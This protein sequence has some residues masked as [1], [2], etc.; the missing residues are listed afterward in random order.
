MLHSHKSLT[1]LIRYFKNKHLGK[2]CFIIGNGPSINLMDLDCLKN[3][4]TIGTNYTFLK[5]EIK[6]PYICI[7]DT[8]RMQ[9]LALY[10][11]NIFS[12]KIIFYASHTGPTWDSIVPS[13]LNRTVVL[14]FLENEINFSEDIKKGIYCNKKM[15]SVVF[16]AIQIAV[17]MGASEIYLI[18]VDQD[19]KKDQLWFHGKQGKPHKEMQCNG[20]RNVIGHNFNYSYETQFKPAIEFYHEK[21]KEKNIKLINAGVGGKLDAIPRIKFESL[22]Q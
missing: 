9:E 7:S 18:G 19:Y 11:K 22:F 21:L 2:R 10:D 6:T 15:A 17:Y 5:E 13:L 16:P 20:T 1:Y 4:F 14:H 12:E 3:E 8:F